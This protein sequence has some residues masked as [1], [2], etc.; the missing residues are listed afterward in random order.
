MQVF[1]T[2]ASGF[3]GAAVVTQLLDAGHHVVALARSPQ[4]AERL[5][6]QRADVHPGDLDDPDSL[7]AAAK[8]AD[9]VIHLAFQHGEPYDQAAGAD[10]RAIAAIGDVL[11][12]SGRPFVV[13]SGTLLL[14]PGRVG[15]EADPPDPAS[16]GAAR[17]GAE[18]TALALADR[19]VRVSVVRLAP[20]VHDQVRRGFVG[21]LIDTA[22]RTGISA[23]VGDGS[24]RWPT[25][26]RQDA[27]RLFRLAMDSAPAGSVLHAVGEDGVR[28]RAIAEFIGG[29][30]G[31][32]VRSVP[33][34]Q[35]EAHFGRLSSVVGT[36]APASSIATRR[37]LGWQPSGPGL[38]DDLAHGRFFTEAQR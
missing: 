12:G 27:A 5:T 36:D 33:A 16:P 18:Q 32:P 9:G 15:T 35:A 26:H 28:L 17:A 37:L 25:V 31:I 1:V 6:A 21:A 4:S 30:L 29:R 13:T 2:G 14:A 3:I 7:R 20:S 11:A 8:A 23:Y 10:R 24:Q 38:L 22:E 19:G 34:D